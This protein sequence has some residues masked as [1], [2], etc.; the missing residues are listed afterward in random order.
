MNVRFAILILLLAAPAAWSAFPPRDAGH[1]GLPGGPSAAETRLGEL[2]EARR[3]GLRR[4]S[5][6]AAKGAAPATFGLLVIPVDFTDARLPDPWDTRATAERLFAPDGESLSRYFAAA[7]GGRLDLQITLG[8]LVRL[9]GPR[10]DYS[11]IGWQGFTRTRALAREALEAVRDS[12]LDFAAFDND[13]ADG[14]P[15][16]GDDDG[17]VD[18]VLILHAGVGQENDPALGLVQPLQFFLA[19]P[20]V[21]RGVT[22]SFYAV[23]SLRSGPGIWAHETAHLLGLEDRYDFELQPAGESEVQS[24]GGLGRFSLMASGAWGTGGGWGAALPDAYSLL[25]VGWADTIQGRGSVTLQPVVAGGHAAVIRPVGS[26][27]AEFILGECRDPVLAAPF[28]AALWAGHLILYHVDESLPVGQSDVD[29][30]G[31]RYLRVNVIEADGDRGLLDGADPGGL[32]DLFPGA[33]G[34]TAL[35]AAGYP[36]TRGHGGATGLTLGGIAAG[37]PG[38]V[39]FTVYPPPGLEA[40]PVFGI[41]PDRTRLDLGAVAAGAPFD[42]LN[43]R[44]E[45]GEGETWGTFTGGAAVLDLPL[46]PGGDGVYRPLDAVPWIPVGDPPPGAFTRFLLTFADGDWSS[47]T[48]IRDWVW[49]SAGESLDFAGDWPGVWTVA[50]PGP[51]T[52]TVW[53]RWEPGNDLRLDG[54]PVLA[55]TGA[56]FSSA[57]AWPQVNYQ[58]RA[59]VTLTSGPLGPD[60]LGVRLTHAVEL[61]RRDAASLMD[62]ATLFWV[63]PDGAEIPAVPLAGWPATVSTLAVN[64][65]QGLGSFAGDTLSVRD[66]SVVWQ[67]DRIA[68]PDGGGPWRLRLAF[69]S[70]TLWR[71]QGW[72]VAGLDPLASLEDPGGFRAAWQGSALRWTWP[73]R[74][75]PPTEWIVQTGDPRTDRWEDAL[76][77]TGSAPAADGWFGT[78]GR[79]IPGTAGRTGARWVRVIARGGPGWLGTQPLVVPG[80]AARAPDPHL[81]CWPN[82]AVGQLQILTDVPEGARPRLAVYDLRGRLVFLRDAGPGR[83]SWTWDLRGNGGWPL[84][85][86]TYIL[87]LEG[88]DPVVPHKVVLL[89]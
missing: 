31:D 12:G 84:P 66:G 77:L 11:D 42:D 76:V 71:R 15:A 21:Q 74:E 19:D 48:M 36:S 65:L 3:E 34:V 79:T 9:G 6:D 51:D 68:R 8:P 80:I 30:F 43:V 17:Q 69:A 49:N 67:V 38:G 13:G 59:H 54:G 55:C 63:G 1:S 7:S 28:D 87:R 53:H 10:R 86:G 5:L 78:G 2:R 50:W 73:W 44:V 61:E 70:N 83:Q 26:G 41:D 25:A 20:V 32:G 23:A 81:T 24:R 72:F 89:H 39:A 64:A 14:I 46:V 18:G 22:A 52:A 62:A 56:E 57:G 4:R 85:A 47:P 45:L 88:L 35:P 29:V 60:V 40:V 58:N 27:A 82:P 16:S 37:D 33:G 75:S